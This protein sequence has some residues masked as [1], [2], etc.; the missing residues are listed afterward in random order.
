MPGVEISSREKWKWT[1]SE[2]IS[3]IEMA[4]N[5]VVVEVVSSV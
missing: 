2:N 4:R 1:N 3:Y 5:V